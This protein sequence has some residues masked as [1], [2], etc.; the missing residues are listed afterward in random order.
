[1]NCIVAS[2]SKNSMF[3]DELL[4][5]CSK[6]VQKKGPGRK[7]NPGHS[8]PKQASNWSKEQ[9]TNTTQSAIL[10]LPL[11]NMLKFVDEFLSFYI[12]LPELPGPQN[13]KPCW[14]LT[15]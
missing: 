3:L 11:L 14:F 10:T 13:K 7:S 12:F 5:N 4:M 9:T 1:M 6:F 2:L 15:I 8:H